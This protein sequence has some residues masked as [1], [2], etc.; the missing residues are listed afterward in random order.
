MSHLNMNS[1]EHFI[2]QEKIYADK[3]LKNLQILDD[4]FFESEYYLLESV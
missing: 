2:K 4:R 3:F 1:Y